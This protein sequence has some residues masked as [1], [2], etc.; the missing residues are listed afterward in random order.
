MTKL[1]MHGHNKARSNREI[2]IGSFLRGVV[3]CK[4]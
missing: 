3:Y 2:G 4:D 1:I